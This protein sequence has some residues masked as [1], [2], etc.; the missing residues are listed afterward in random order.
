MSH[1]L[2]VVVSLHQQ[3]QGP[4]RKR[5]P[6]GAADVTAARPTAPAPGPTGADSA[7]QE[8][9]QAKP[10]DQRPV[11]KMR[12]LDQHGMSLRISPACLAG[13]ECDRKKDVWSP[14]RLRQ[15]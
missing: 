6:W 14:G 11:R 10:G 7:K 5:T 15:E 12:A 2:W 1:P 3:G 8:C 13:H 9:S 4:G